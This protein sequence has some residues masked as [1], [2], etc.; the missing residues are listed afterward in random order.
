MLS[1][2]ATPPNKHAQV[3]PTTAAAAA[4]A[5]PVPGRAQ[6]LPVLALLATVGLLAAAGLV[7]AGGTLSGPAEHVEATFPAT[8]EQ[9]SGPFEVGQ[10]V[11]TSFGAMS[12]G[13][14][15]RID[16]LTS[17][18]LAGMT[19]GINGLVKEK[20]SRVQAAVTFTN[21][22]D[23][24]VR[25]APER[26]TL[27]TSQGGDPIKITSSSVPSGVLEPDASIDLRADFTV[28]QKAQRFWIDFDDPT[29]GKLTVGLGRLKQV[30]GGRPASPAAQQALIDA[31][32]GAAASTHGEHGGG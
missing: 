15:E 6:V 30:S 25:F 10:D 18:D 31:S 8:G 7:V 26:M 2:W 3:L 13:H 27:R 4:T 21:L 5:R 9:P 28:P 29:R 12:I 1:P 23:R 16:G 32:G 11:P 17:R 14:A 24:P 22:L 19:H 20:M